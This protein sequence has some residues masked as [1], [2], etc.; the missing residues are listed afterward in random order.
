VLSSPP[1]IPDGSQFA[2]QRDLHGT[3]RGTYLAVDAAGNVSPLDPM[4]YASW[5]GG[6]Y[7]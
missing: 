2:I 3:D 7:P 1:P 6:S 4:T 5:N